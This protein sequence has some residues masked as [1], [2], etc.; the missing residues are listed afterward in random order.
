MTTFVKPVHKSIVSTNKND[1]DRYRYRYE[2]NRIANTKRLA[3]K[4]LNKNKRIRIHLKDNPRTGQC[5]SCGLEIGDSYLNCWGK[6]ATVKLTQ[7]HHLAYHADD[8]LKDTIELCPSCH[9]KESYRL[10]QLTGLAKGW[11]R[12]RRLEN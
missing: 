5:Q 10:G 11:T 6:K 7:I 4:L 1:D 2:Q 9:S 8:P 3:F 12:R